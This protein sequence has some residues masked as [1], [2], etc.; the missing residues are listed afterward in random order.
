MA[1]YLL[2]LRKATFNA[3]FKG[4]VNRRLLGFVLSASIVLI[5]AGLFSGSTV[6]AEPLTGELRGV[7]LRSNNRPLAQVAIV[8]HNVEDN[9]DRTAMSGPDGSFAVLNLKPGEYQV[10]ASKAGFIS[11]AAKIVGLAAGDSIHLDMTLENDSV[12]PAARTY[13]SRGSTRCGHRFG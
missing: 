9:M 8:L 11:P 13:P 3:P 6:C 5:Q 4:T 2:T 7:T 12:N 1:L 10:T